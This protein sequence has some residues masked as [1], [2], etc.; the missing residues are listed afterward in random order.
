MSKDLHLKYRPQKL[1]DVIGQEATVRSLRNLLRITANAPRTYLFVGP[2][3]VGKTTCARI[4][5]RRLSIPVGNVVEIDGATFTGIDEARRIKDLVQSPALGSDRR[6]M[7][8]VDECH[9]LSKQ[10]WDSWL[11][12]M[13]EPPAHLYIALCTTE[14]SKVPDTVKTRFHCYRLD[15]VSE[16]ELGKL[17]EQVK[18]KE[19]LAV[20]DEVLDYIAAQSNG[21]PR[22]ALMYLSQCRDVQSVKRARG[23]VRKAEIATEGDEVGIARLLVAGNRS[24]P[25]YMKAVEKVA[26]LEAESIR[27][28]TVRYVA[29]VMRKQQQP[30]KAASLAGVLEAFSQ[31]YNASD[32]DAPLLLSIAGCIL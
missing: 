27:I 3:G 5:R 30:K 23:I 31:P 1:D 10:A 17:L 25:T 16:E 19:S 24:W 7:L 13:E 8:I 12:V 22:Q 14:V 2:S 21:S 20:S 26:K 9:R 11:K 28:V 18:R 6:R 15:P 29:A 32:G 4:I